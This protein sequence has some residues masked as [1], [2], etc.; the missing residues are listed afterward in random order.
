[1][2]QFTIIQPLTPTITDDDVLACHCHIAHTESQ[3][4]S[5]VQVH[6]ASINQLAVITEETHDHVPLQMNMATITRKLSNVSCHKR[7]RGLIRKLRK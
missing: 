5:T 2:R 7:E 6:K 3:T 1:M 4:P